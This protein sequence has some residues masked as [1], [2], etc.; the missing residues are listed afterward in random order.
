[1]TDRLFLTVAGALTNGGDILV[2]VAVV[3][4]ITGLAGQAW[5]AGE[6][7]SRWRVGMATTWV[8]GA[9]MVLMI[10]AGWLP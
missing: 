9:G 2:A 10:L 7:S 1:M 5:A 4:L 6:P 8:L 3:L